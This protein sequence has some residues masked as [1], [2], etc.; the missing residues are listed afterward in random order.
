MNFGIYIPSATGF[1]P[2][3]IIA[4]PANWRPAELYA[5]L[6]RN[7]YAN[8]DWLLSYRWVR[9]KLYVD[10][11]VPGIIENDVLCVLVRIAE[12]AAA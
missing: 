8:P 4:V 1:T 10:F 6:R 3:G 5:A 11:S 12:E 2:R 9:G 7:G